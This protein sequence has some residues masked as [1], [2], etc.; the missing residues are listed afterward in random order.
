MSGALDAALASPAF[1]AYLGLVA[2]F[3]LA[4]GVEVLVSAR[5]ARARQ[6]ALVS[7]PRLFPVMVLL[8]AALLAAPPLEVVA[9]A[10]PF[11]WD[12]AA[13]ALV[14]LGLA[15][16]LRVWTLR[17]LGRA[18]NVRIVLPE[19]IVTDGPYA[20]IRHPNYLV[21]VL[22]V[23]ALPLVHG[24]WLSALALS[25]L[26]AAVL[27]ARIRTEEAALATLPAWRAAMADRKRLLPGVF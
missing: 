6:A 23:A 7:E 20:W 11:R 10:R 14:V 2:L 13:G 24:A 16:A 1:R 12:L 15:T 5:R 3:A 9:L 25:A 19:A 21:V 4:R 18:W 17:T 22:E 26:N 8:H 27:A